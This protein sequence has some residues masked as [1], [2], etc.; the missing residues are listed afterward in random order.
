MYECCMNDVYIAEPSK[1]VTVLSVLLN[2]NKVVNQSMNTVVTVIVV[3]SCEDRLQPYWSHVL[4]CY[5][6]SNTKWEI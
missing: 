3:Q 6:H 5:G 2:C 4:S 1:I